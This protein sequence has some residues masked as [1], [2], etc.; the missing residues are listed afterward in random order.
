ML[1]TR[2]ITEYRLRC[3]GLEE[4]SMRIIRTLE[5]MRLKAKAFLTQ[6]LPDFQV[7]SGHRDID[8]ISG[9]HSATIERLYNIR[10]ECVLRFLIPRCS[11]LAAFMCIFYFILHLEK[12]FQTKLVH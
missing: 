3:Q 5:A 7:S 11:G 10:N 12:P 6:L 4:A 2:V 8:E 1:Y 9:S